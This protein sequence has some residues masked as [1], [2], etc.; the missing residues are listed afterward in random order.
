MAVR[1]ESFWG[2][3]SYKHPPLTEELLALAEETLGVTLPLEYVELLRIQNGGFTAG[4]AFP[5]SVKTTWADD[6]VPLD[7]LCG[8]VAGDDTDSAQNLMDN[9]Y[10]CEEWHLPPRQVLIAGDGHWWIS[11]DYRRGP[12]PS[13]AWIDVG[14]AACLRRPAC[15]YPGPTAPPGSSALPMTPD[16]QPCAHRPD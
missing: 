2:D 8:I 12:T 5:T 6:H 7:E 13:V 4:F 1:D 9:A 3:N 16:P 14:Y 10:M 15:A 11:L